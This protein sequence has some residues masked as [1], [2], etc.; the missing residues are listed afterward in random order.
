METQTNLTS[1]R[2]PPSDA[3]G[4]MAVMGKDGDTKFFWNS[5]SQEQV[6]AAREVFTEHRRKGYLAFHMSAKGDQGEQM[7]AFD[8]EAGSILFIPQMQGG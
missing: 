3:T 7:T 1:S 4:H 8:P 2:Q 5:K 6:E